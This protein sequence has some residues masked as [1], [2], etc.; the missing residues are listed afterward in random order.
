M[1]MVLLKAFVV[2]SQAGSYHEAAK[3]LFI[4]QSALTK[5]SISWKIF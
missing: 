5:K 1:D 4:T 2:L 3:R